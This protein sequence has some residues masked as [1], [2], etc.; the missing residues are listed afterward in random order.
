MILVTF[1]I[2][3]ITTVVVIASFLLLPLHQ[4]K[5]KIEEI[6][7]IKHNKATIPD[8]RP[9]LNFRN[10][11]M[12]VCMLSESEKG[13]KYWNRLQALEFQ[14]AYILLKQAASPLTLHST[15]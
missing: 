11:M 2:G 15:V 14:Q 10:I 8:L 7:N 9:V 4:K 5:K 3:N 1:G 12:C 13:Q 6:F